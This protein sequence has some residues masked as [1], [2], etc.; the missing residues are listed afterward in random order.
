LIALSSRSS[1]RPAGTVRIVDA[2]QAVADQQ[3]EDRVVYPE[4]AEH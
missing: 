1:F 4:N 3:L 2:I